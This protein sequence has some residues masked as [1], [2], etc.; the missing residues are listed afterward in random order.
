MGRSTAENDQPEDIA[1]DIVE[2]M[3]YDKEKVEH[4]TKF[5]ERLKHLSKEKVEPLIMRRKYAHA[6]LPTLKS[7]KTVV[8][9][10]VVFDKEFESEE[11]IE[12]YVLNVIKKIEN[13]DGAIF[14]LEITVSLENE[15]K[16]ELPAI[17]KALKDTFYFEIKFIQKQIEVDKTILESYTLDPMKLLSDYIEQAFSSY[18]KKDK[19][20]ATAKIILKGLIEESE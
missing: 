6:A 3:E 15:M 16:L 20:E 18:D 19:L 5:F 1:A 10:R 11:T 7:C 14:R 8:E 2:F 4:L 17:E 12:E 9:Y 13:L